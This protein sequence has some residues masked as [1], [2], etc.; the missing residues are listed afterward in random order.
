MLVEEPL[1]LPT[2]VALLPYS[3]NE[4]ATISHLLHV[5]ALGRRVLHLN[6]GIR[7]Q[8]IFVLEVNGHGAAPRKMVKGVIPLICTW[9]S[10]G[11]WWLPELILAG[12]PFRCLQPHSQIFLSLT[13]E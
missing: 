4:F 8:S 10:L 11:G 12:L 1:F 9:L 5:S 6:P 7:A 2:H 3:T 13:T